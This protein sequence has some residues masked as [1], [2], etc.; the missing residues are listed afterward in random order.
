MNIDLLNRDYKGV[1]QLIDVRP[2][3]DEKFLTLDYDFLYIEEFILC[4]LS[5]RKTQLFRLSLG[6]EL[7]LWKD[8]ILD[9]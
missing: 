3:I 6:K 5:E 8:E 2:W 4:V 7:D 1:Y 9:L